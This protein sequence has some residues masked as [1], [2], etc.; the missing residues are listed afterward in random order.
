MQSTTLKNGRVTKYPSKI[1]GCH[2]VLFR[3]KLVSLDECIKQ[4]QTLKGKQKA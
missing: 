2:K 1:V 3:Q 4:I